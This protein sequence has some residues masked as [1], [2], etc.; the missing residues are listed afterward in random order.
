[1]FESAELGHSITK[2]AYARQVPRLREALL[3][4]QFD[5]FQDA[6]FPV[7]V[8]IGGV[9]GAGKGETVNLLNEWMDPRHIRTVAFGEPTDEERERPPMWRY[10]RALPPKGKIGILFGHWYTQTI[11]DRVGHAT[12]HPQLV[13]SLEEITRFER[14]LADE[15]ALI[16]KFWFHL[17]KA[18]QKKR[19][20][21]LEADP[22]TRWK[23]SDLEWKHF[24]HYDRFR[25]ISEF[26][27][28]ETSSATSPWFVVEAV[29]SNYRN[30]AVG[31]TLLTALRARLDRKASKAKENPVAPT[32]PPI[33]KRDILGSLDLT[34]SLD[35]HKY[36]KLLDRYH[37]RLN[38]LSRRLRTSGQSVVLAFEGNDAA[39][40]GGAIRRIARALDARQYRIIPIAAP[41]EEERAQP[42]LWRFWR[43]VPGHGQFSIF[44]RSWYG[45]VL[46]ERVEG[47]AAEYDWMRAY[48]EINDFERQLADNGAIVVKFWLAISK[49]E[50]HRRFLERE[51]TAFK[52]FK[53]TP[54][55]WRNRKKWHAYESAVCDMIDR[56]STDIAPWTLV[57]ADDKLHARIK[58][59]KTLCGRMEDALD[60]R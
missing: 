32:Q 20:K 24:K 45:R 39:G 42:Y 35:R 25:K 30:L 28:R 41:T 59:L 6:S 21:S 12:R 52:R 56:T 27:L 55:D 37:A 36:E 14:M 58:V 7:I 53:I 51:K 38:L 31:R 13:Q 57:E 4:A 54:E 16:L 34:L 44:D 46:V 60:S 11:L 1:M 50:Q 33:D 26:T 23:V 17:S 10:W 15:G 19:L 5:L 47:F 8:L 18:A 2:Q 40:K 3:D 9:D 22:G 29:D 43:Q 49:E 48:E